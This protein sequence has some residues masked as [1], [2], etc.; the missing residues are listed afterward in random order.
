MNST[1]TESG[2]DF[3]LRGLTLA[4]ALHDPF[5]LQGS[6]MHGGQERDGLFVSSDA[7]HAY[8]FTIA[9]TKEKAIKDAEKI[10]GL[11]ADLKRKPDNAYKLAAGWFVTLDEPTADQ[12]GAVKEVE[13]RTGVTVHALSISTLSQ[14][15]CDSE[16]YMHRRG[17]APFGSVAF[18]PGPSTSDVRVNVDI[19]GANDICSI[20]DVVMS[21]LSG[22]RRLIIGDF[23]VGKSH[24]LREVYLSLRK[25]HFRRKK[26]SPFPIHI[27]LREC[28]GLR[29]PAEILRRHAE[30]IG[31]PNPDSLISAWR[32]GACVL[33][34][35]GFDEIVPVRWLGQAADLKGVRWEALAPVR[36][37]IQ[38]SPAQTGVLVAGRSHYF[39]SNGEMADALDLRSHDV[40]TMRDFSDD[41]VAAYLAAASVTWQVPDW[42]PS[43]PL[44]ISYLISMGEEAGGTFWNSTSHAAAW[45]ALLEE[46]CRRESQMYEAVRPEV[47]RAI[48]A[49]VATLA[50]S[51]GND[52][53]PVDMSMMR[54]AFMSVNNRQPDEEGLQLLLRLPGLAIN[55]LDA[56]SDSR[57]FVDSDLAETAYAVDLAEHILNPHDPAHP[58][59]GLASWVSA[60]S[61]L[62]IEVAAEILGEAQYGTKA[63]L[64]V[65]TSRQS[66]NRNDAVLADLLNV[67]SHLRVDEKVSN[68]YVVE[69]VYFRS[70]AP[71]GGDAISSSTSFQE[72][73]FERLDISAL[74]DG[75]TMPFF[76]KCLVGLLDGV[77]SVP[78]WLAPRFVDTDVE[79]YSSNSQTTAGI[80]QLKLDPRTKIALTILKKIYGQRGSGRKEGA[81]V[82]GL[83]HASRQLVPSVLGQLVSDGWIQKTSAGRNFIYVGTKSRRAAALQALNAPG[84]FRL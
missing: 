2:P 8:E 47:I 58:L 18:S 35:D 34:L 66:S 69:G 57:L 72:C 1:V 61:S 53:G 22:K 52:I 82:R 25:E 32:A 80:L 20:E 56:G 68:T 65:A 63:V 59:T 5:G 42:L 29:S 19:H 73:V 30:E 36:R 14:R 62:G 9:R 23:G 6:V 75:Q 21:L 27:N 26:L 16:A 13:R 64:S 11:L 24:A 7:I 76:Q 17:N 51:T 43:R 28:A 3:E 44:L 71:V 50:R 45:R 60:S 46:I 12:R 33:L 83:D 84:D 15:V 54:E 38:E 41:Q 67:A 48:V 49:R 74:E 4:R 77:S 40:L 37:L 31:F 70:L 10:A 79:K 55:G 81:L 39:S 78:S